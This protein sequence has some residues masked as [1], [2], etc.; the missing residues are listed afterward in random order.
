[1]RYALHEEQ[2]S[3]RPLR[4]GGVPRQTAWADPAGPADEPLRQVDP[5]SL[6]SALDRLTLEVLHLNRPLQ[7]AW[8]RLRE[9][10][11]AGVAPSRH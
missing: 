5:R 11:R 7:E 10:L 4:L 9:Q 3:P 6:A 2:S 8:E 1:M